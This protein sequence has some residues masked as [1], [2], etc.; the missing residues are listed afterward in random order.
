M[1]SINVMVLYVVLLLG[2]I[3]CDEFGLR[4]LTG[5]GIVDTIIRLLQKFTGKVQTGRFIVS[6]LL[7]IIMQCIEALTILMAIAYVIECL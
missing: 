1:V 6:L 4:L 5:A 7:V 3:V 2:I